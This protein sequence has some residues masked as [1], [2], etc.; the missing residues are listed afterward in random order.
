MNDVK[1][2]KKKC[3]TGMDTL[4]FMASL[5]KNVKKN[6]EVVYRIQITI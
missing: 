3:E 2:N 4:E 5:K 6:G 1:L